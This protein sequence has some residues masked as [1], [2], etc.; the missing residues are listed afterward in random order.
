MTQASLNKVAFSHFLHKDYQMAT[1]KTSSTSKAQ[2]TKI[3]ISGRGLSFSVLD[4]DHETF[5]LFTRTGISDDVF[6]DLKEQL[7]EA[8]ECITA[9]FLEETTVTING[10]RFTSSWTKIKAQCGNVMPPPTKV[11]DE[12]S[13]SYS[14]ILEIALK[15]EFVNAEVAGF[16]PEK[17]TFD[18]EHIELAKGRKY[19]LLDPYYNHDFLDF[20]ST[21]ATGIIYV[22][23]NK[24]KRY[25]IKRVSGK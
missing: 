23:D 18:L 5:V 22:V 16:D 1:R 8:G 3:V 6:E 21:K 2:K 4:I 7:T 17:L 15:G 10:R 19:A 13:G 12:P 11:Y 24:G 14:V 25:D 20:G 9:P